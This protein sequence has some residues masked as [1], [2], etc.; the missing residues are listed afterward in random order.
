MYSIVCKL[1]CFFYSK[2]PPF[3]DLPYVV[4]SPMLHSHGAIQ[5]TGKF[6]PHFL[7]IYHFTTIYHFTKHFTKLFTMHFTKLFT[8]HFTKHLK[9]F[10]R[11][12]TSTT[13]NFDVN[14][15]TVPKICRLVFQA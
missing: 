8:K 13:E 3:T 9:N 12:F 11:G 7:L 1:D 5:S 4:E 14:S 10:A 6:L 15:F 2:K